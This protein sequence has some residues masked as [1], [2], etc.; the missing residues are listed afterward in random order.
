M[1]NRSKACPYVDSKI[2][3]LLHNTVMPL[4]DLLIQLHHDPPP[5]KSLL[6]PSIL[7][8]Y[9]I[10]KLRFENFAEVVLKC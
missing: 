1:L 6:S 4:K 9:L 8:P 2:W 10:K 3:V 5:P 7:Q